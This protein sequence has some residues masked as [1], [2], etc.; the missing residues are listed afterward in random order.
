MLHTH[1]MRLF[2]DPDFPVQIFQKWTRI[3]AVL[4][5]LWYGTIAILIFMILN[6]EVPLPA[7]DRDA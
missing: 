6:S 5:W 4:L 1:T 3:I 7:F 2:Q